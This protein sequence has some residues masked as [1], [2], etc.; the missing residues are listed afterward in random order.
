[1]TGLLKKIIESQLEILKYV[2]FI[3]S[4]INIRKE[5]YFAKI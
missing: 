4:G 5:K 3:F 2:E 1:M